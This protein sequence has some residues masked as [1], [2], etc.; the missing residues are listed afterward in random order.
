M[1]NFIVDPNISRDEL[2]DE[3]I[4]KEYYQQP[5]NVISNQYGVMARRANDNLT[6]REALFELITSDQARNN[7]AMGFIMQ[8]WLP[9]IYILKES[10]DE[11]KLE[12]KKVLKNWTQEEKELFLSYIKSDQEYYC[13]LYDI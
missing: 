2:S 11:V 1:S 6:I 13:L 9:A 10:N 5:K 7:K 4:L 12:L 8:S 3:E